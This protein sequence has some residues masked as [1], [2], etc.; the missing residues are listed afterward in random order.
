MYFWDSYLVVLD[1]LMFWRGRKNCVDL[2]DLGEEGEERAGTPLIKKKKKKALFSLVLC[3][4]RNNPI[5]CADFCK[6]YFLVTSIIDMLH[7]WGLLHF[8]LQ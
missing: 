8:C 6:A 2:G 1:C 5:P 4:L 3:I 7:F